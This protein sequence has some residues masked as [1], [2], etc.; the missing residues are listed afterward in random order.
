MNFPTS[1]DTE[2]AEWALAQDLV[3]LTLNGAIVDLTGTTMT[4]NETGE[5]ANLN[6]PTYL[7]FLTEDTGGSFEIVKVTGTATGGVCTVERGVLSSTA[8]T[9]SDDAQAA[10]D[11]VSVHLGSIR[12][13]LLGIEKYH[14]LVGVEASLPATCDPGESYLATDTDKLFYAVAT[15]TWREINELD[16]DT[17]EASSLLD[18]DHTDYHTAARKLTW[19]GNL[20]GVHITKTAHNHDGTADDGQP[21]AR[22]INGL[23]SARPATP[24]FDGQV[25]YSNDTGDLWVGNSSVWIKYSVMPTETI[26]MFEEDCPQGWSRLSAMDDK[27]PRGAPTGVY[28]GFSD[29]GAATHTHDMP[30]VVN[31]V[32]SIVA[33][34]GVELISSGHHGHS[35]DRHSWIAGVEECTYN[36]QFSTLMEFWRGHSSHQH[37]VTFPA[38]NTLGAGNN[39]ATS[40]AETSL[41]P[42]VNLVFCEKD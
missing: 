29:G 10:Q 26:I 18:D 33:Q 20:A 15:D 28:T 6:V 24:D 25:Y 14:S 2:A 34:T 11:P 1:Y 21:A 42:Y 31:H 27:Y 4:F 17:L 35:K 37:S 22:F 7:T 16:H 32:H 39:P 13:L 12:T 36:G 5:V 3:V 41:I 8:M 30:D 40:G 38:H 19:H 23:E 9:H